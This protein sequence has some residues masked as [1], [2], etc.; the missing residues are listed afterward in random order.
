VITDWEQALAECEARIDAA[1]AGLDGGVGATTAV[2]P[3]AIPAID[4]PC[5]AVFEGRARALV[6]RGIELERRLETERDR[7]RS[8]LR[9]LPRMPP[10]ERAW[11]LEVKA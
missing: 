11:H 1:A 2:A 3:F 7:V 4:G 6:E 8:E 5:P 10:I 9:R